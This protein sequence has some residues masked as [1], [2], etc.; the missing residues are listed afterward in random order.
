MI[1][2][3]NYAVVANELADIFNKEPELR[4]H[5][6][7]QWMEAKADRKPHDDGMF[8]AIRLTQERYFLIMST[9][10]THQTSG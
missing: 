9:L 10:T 4:M 1:S 3:N 7:R 6:R 5:I 8:F 2:E